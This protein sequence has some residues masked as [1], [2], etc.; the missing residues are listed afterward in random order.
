M[1]L[2]AD[3]QEKMKLLS[4]AQRRTIILIVGGKMAGVPLTRLLKTPYSCRCCGYVAGRS[5]ESREVRK[6]TLADHE[7]KS[8]KRPGQKW[9]FAANASTYYRDWKPSKYFSDCLSQA[10]TELFDAALN[11][12]LQMLQIAAP[13]AAREAWRVVKEGEIE[14]NRLVA[15]FGILDRAALKT[16]DK[17][18]DKVERWLAALRGVEDTEE[19]EP[20]ADSGPEGNDI[21]DDWPSSERDPGEDTP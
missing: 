3:L 5:G 14:R 12:A 13:E 7:V 9:Q 17:T 20:V 11:E 19:D 16:A 4:S 6:Q 1:N 2:S 8:C 21:S 10:E 18:N 15:A